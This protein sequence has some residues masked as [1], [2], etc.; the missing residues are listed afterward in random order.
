MTSALSRVPIPKRRQLAATLGLFATL[1]VAVGAVGMTGASPVVVRV[2]AAITLVVAALLA[3]LAWG[4]ARSVALELAEARLDRAIEETM[5]AGD[6]QLSCGCG[7][8]HDPDELHVTDEDGCRHD[9]TGADCAHNC[10]SCVL[11]A[12]RP[13][14]SVP[15]A[16]RTR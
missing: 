3:L 15:R 13:S 16:D 5:R 14:P 6:G 10:Q 1:F 2:F 8:E 11:A 9:G 12:L 7:H 4:V